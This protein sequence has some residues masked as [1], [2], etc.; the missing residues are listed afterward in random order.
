MNCAGPDHFI[1]QWVHV[2]SMI[3]HKRS[4]IIKRSDLTFANFLAVVYCY[5]V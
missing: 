5:I 1:P 4:R 2:S 3:S